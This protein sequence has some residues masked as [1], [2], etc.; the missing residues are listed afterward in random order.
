MAMAGVKG[1]AGN[2]FPDYGVRAPAKSKQTPMELTRK[3]LSQA[4][5]TLLKPQKVKGLFKDDKP[6]QIQDF[7]ARSLFDKRNS[8]IY[9][10]FNQILSSRSTA[11]DKQ[12]AFLDIL[13]NIIELKKS[14]REQAS[15][16][17][18]LEMGQTPQDWHL[19]IYLHGNEICQLTPP[20]EIDLPAQTQGL[21]LF[22]ILTYQCETPPTKGDDES[23]AKYFT[24]LLKISSSMPKETQDKTDKATVTVIQC[25]GA[26]TSFLPFEVRQ[27]IRF[28]ILPPNMHQRDD[29]FSLIINGKLITSLALTRDTLKTARH[30]QV[31]FY[32][33]QSSTKPA[34]TSETIGELNTQLTSTL[35]FQGK[36]AVLLKARAKLP[37][38]KKDCL[39]IVMSPPAVSN[40]ER[41]CSCQLLIN[42]EVLKNSDYN[43][44]TFTCDGGGAKVLSDDYSAY[45]VATAPELAE[46]PTLTKEED[47]EQLLIQKQ[48]NDKKTHAIKTLRELQQQIQEIKD[49]SHTQHQL[50]AKTAETER[51]L[52]DLLLDC[53]FAAKNKLLQDAIS[54]TYQQVQKKRNDVGQYPIQFGGYPCST[55]G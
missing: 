13:D 28:E 48:Y 31:L 40:K 27:A 18:K 34:Y 49:T 33:L 26:L 19:S 14:C 9:D 24:A 55:A 21:L 39:S 17:F 29:N 37:P 41:T 47:I 52:D 7:T 44:N 4:L 42:G 46:L 54:N 5:A 51:Q 30:N 1:V 16:G 2:Q 23:F 10:A 53:G 6:P 35:P 45:L 11:E 32:L 22:K 43:V 8:A 38:H 12:N 15:L 50:L 20:P 25:S 36:L 3:K